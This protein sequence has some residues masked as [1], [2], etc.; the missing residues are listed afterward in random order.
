MQERKK[1]LFTRIN[2]EI[3]VQTDEKMRLL[4]K[5]TPKIKVSIWHT[6]LPILQ[7]NKKIKKEFK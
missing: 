2:L 3:S 7:N 6:T 4:T 5:F 1:C